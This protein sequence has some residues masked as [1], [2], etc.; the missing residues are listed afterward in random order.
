[1]C[2]SHICP[3]KK[4]PL[5]DR[6]GFLFDGLDEV[7]KKYSPETVFVEDIFTNIKYPYTA[8]LMAHARAMVFL[9]AARHKISVE[10][11]SPASIKKAV[12]GR[13][14]ASKEQMKRMISNVV[15]LPESEPFD[16]YDAI[17][18]GLGSFIIKWKSSF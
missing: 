4:W 14:N 2:A 17:A 18:I 6:L 12:C 7:F 15:S 10:T 8:I 13:G 5:Q 11:Y 3:P 1:M 9:V 16:T